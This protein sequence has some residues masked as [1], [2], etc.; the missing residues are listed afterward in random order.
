MLDELRASG[1]SSPAAAPRR[2]GGRGATALPPM[3]ENAAVVPSLAPAAAASEAAPAVPTPSPSP[4]PAPKPAA[5]APPPAPA[6][7]PA[8]DPGAASTTP[9]ARDRAS[10]EAFV[11]ASQVGVAVPADPEAVSA[12]AALAAS[13]RAEAHSKALEAEFGEPDAA[14][15]WPRSPGDHAELSKASSVSGMAG[16]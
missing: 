11:P 5:G 1:H 3:A 9:V 13:E 14:P 8:S 7:A 6:P 10:G 4:P 15:E 16:V 12:A 2:E